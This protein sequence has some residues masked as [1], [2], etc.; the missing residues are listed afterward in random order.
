MASEVTGEERE[1]C[2]EK[3]VSRYPGYASYT[4]RTGDRQI[5]VIVLTPQD[6]MN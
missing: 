4:A 3:D 5:P 6:R 1:R 2:W